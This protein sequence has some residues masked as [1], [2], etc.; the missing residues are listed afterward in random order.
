MILENGW[1]PLLE[2]Y[3]MRPHYLRALFSPDSNNVP[4]FP[5]GGE[6]TDTIFV[7]TRGPFLILSLAWFV[8]VD[9][10]AFPG[11]PQTETKIIEDATMET[12]NGTQYQIQTVIE[13]PLAVRISVEDSGRSLCSWSPGSTPGP[14]DVGL[15]GLAGIAA[16][17]ANPVPNELEFGKGRVRTLPHP[18]LMAP[19]ASITVGLTP[20]G[21]DNWTINPGPAYIYVFFAGIYLERVVT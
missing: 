15:D 12:Q 2:R 21:A 3:Y 8:E 19:G 5:A 20:I 1:Q 13:K 7:D 16:H 17:P 14:Y 6:V 10:A 9:N 11:I 4:V 18:M